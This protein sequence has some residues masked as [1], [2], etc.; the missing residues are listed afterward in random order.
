MAVLNVLKVLSAAGKLGNSAA[1]GCVNYRGQIQKL[2]DQ[3]HSLD[4]VVGVHREFVMHLRKHDSFD[5]AGDSVL[6]KPLFQSICAK[7]PPPNTFQSQRSGRGSSWRSARGG[8][9]K[10]ERPPPKDG[11]YVCKGEHFACDCLEREGGS[12]GRGMVPIAVAT[13]CPFQRGL[14]Q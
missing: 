5:V 8:S 14:H 10:L 13:N 2:L 6:G 1:A 7:L 9:L 11:C 12:Q 4:V 3:G